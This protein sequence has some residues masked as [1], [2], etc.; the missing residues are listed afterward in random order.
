MVSAVICGLLLYSCTPTEPVDPNSQVKANP[1]V[2]WR[3][4]QVGSE[5][6]MNQVYSSSIRLFEDGSITAYN[7]NFKLAVRSPQGV[8][9]DAPVPAEYKADYGKVTWY[10]DK[11]N[12]A[13]DTHT[14]MLVFGL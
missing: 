11:N 9:S 10:Q 2:Y 6:S 13:G 8:W 1:Q 3:V 14:Q 7:K 5:I 4:T 12:Y